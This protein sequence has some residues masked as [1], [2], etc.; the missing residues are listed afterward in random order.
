[1][2]DGRTLLTIADVCGKGL[3][4]ALVSATLHTMVHG[5]IAAGM[6][7]RNLMRSLSTYLGTSLSDESFVT[8]V[9]VAVDPATGAVECVNAGH[10]PALLLV[11]PGKDPVPLASGSNLPL[12]LDPTEELEVHSHQMGPGS[13]MALYTDGLTEQTDEAG[14]MLGI[15][16]LSDWLRELWDASG[17]TAAAATGSNPCAAFVRDSGRP[18]RFRPW[19]E[20]LSG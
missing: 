20:G 11:E 16:G 3:A 7:L 1:M 12:G 6:D 9:A 17:T 4:A 15:R 13:L 10:P 19:P 8:M 2:K 18:S 5:S 14:E